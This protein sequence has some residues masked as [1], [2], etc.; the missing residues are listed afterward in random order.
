MEH[1]IEQA[2]DDLEA[3][4]KVALA[5]VR[6]VR[7]KAAPTDAEQQGFQQEEHLRHART[8]RAY[9]DFLDDNL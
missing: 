9:S 4:L 5:A 8:G 1:E 3:A 7:E 6:R 2:L